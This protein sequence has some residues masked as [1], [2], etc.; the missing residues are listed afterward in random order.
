M[1]GVSIRDGESFES[2]VR[3]F[4]KQCE[5][6]GILAELRKREAY[7]KP[8]EKKKRLNSQSKKRQAQLGK[9]LSKPLGKPQNY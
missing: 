4:K 3:R 6:A 1:S 7:E 5:K 9:P 2:V 8:S